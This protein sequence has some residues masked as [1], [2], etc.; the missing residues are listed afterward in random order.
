VSDSVFGAGTPSV[1]VPDG[2]PVDADVVIVGSGMGGATLAHALRDTGVNVLVV[3]R[4]DFLPREFENW[5][6]EDVF[7]EGRYK[8]TDPWHDA[9]GNPF[10]SGTYYFVGGS[11]KLYGASLPRFREFDFDEVLHPDGPSPAWPFSYDTIEPFYCDAESMYF[12]HGESGADPTEPG[13][14]RPF[15]FPALEHEPQVADLA[16][17]F[18]K[19]G[20]K[21]FSMPMG[22]DRGPGGR[23]VRC[24]TC[25]AYPC[26]V[27]AKADAEICAVRPALESPT[28]RLLTNTTIDRLITD[29]S[30]T[31][32]IAAEATRD[33][34]RLTVRAERFVLAAGA[35][36]TARLLLSSAQHGHANGLAN[37]SDQVGRNYMV[38]TTSFLVGVDPRR[39]ND[40]RFQKTLGINDFYAPQGNGGFPL[41][42][43]QML[44]KL[45]GSMI[46]GARSWVPMPVL[47]FMTSR[48]IDIYLTTEDVPL[49]QNRVVVDGAGRLTVH[50]T[51]SNLSSHRTLRK[52][53][54]KA[55]RRAGYPLV[56]S[57]QLGIESTAH[58]CGTARMGHD[59]TAS[60]VDAGCRAHD[61]AN[62]WIVDGSVFPSSAAVNPALTI[63]ANALRVAA[64]GEV[65]R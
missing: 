31:R 39:R 63:A 15:P 16:A 25:D 13:R 47:D 37:R 45:Q 27:D 52:T 61:V 42:Q 38:H 65:T 11:T 18:A 22:V 34:R 2:G 10:I 41:G 19:Q 8:N 48:S 59:P 62:L 50:W 32:V 44:G 14:S 53:M 33:G 43:V 23:C 21:P 35:V 51:P 54:T 30:G 56:F 3:E 46:K 6:P 1:V 40:V 57:Q 49:A 26:M 29:A 36:N 7:I 64:L 4:G 60:V 12:V 9:D 24:R 17:S 20:L 55:L 28:V 5:S 58:Q